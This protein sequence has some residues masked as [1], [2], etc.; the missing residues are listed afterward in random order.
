MYHEPNKRTDTSLWQLRNREVGPVP[1][2]PGL[3]ACGSER[4]KA[5]YGKDMSPRLQSRRRAMSGANRETETWYK[6]DGMGELAPHTSESRR[7]GMSATN[8]ERSPWFS[9]GGKPRGC[10]SVPRSK[11][12]TRPGAKRT[13]P[14]RV[15]TWGGL[16]A[17]LRPVSNYRKG[18]SGPGS[19]VS[20][21]R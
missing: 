7:R 17:V 18:G 21:V 20:V 5:A 15:L 6:A 3:V 8:R 4:G 2:G 9:A 1:V 12:T 19:N 14:Q 13:G 16:T 11:A 10:A